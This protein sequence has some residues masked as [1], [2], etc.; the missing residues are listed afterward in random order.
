MLQDGKEGFPITSLLSFKSPVT[1]FKP[2]NESRINYHSTNHVSPT[3]MRVVKRT[4]TINE[5]VQ[6]E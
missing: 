1:F 2:F 5:Q 4:K 6:S 3:I